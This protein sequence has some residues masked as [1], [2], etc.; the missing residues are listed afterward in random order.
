MSDAK[1]L[2]VDDEIDVLELCARILRS[3][4]YDVQTAQDGREAIDLA[5]GQHFDLLL[6]DIKMPGMSGLDIA[7]A[8]RKS[9]PGVICIAMT[10]FGTIDMVLDALKLGIDE[11]ILKPF[12]PQ[13]LKTTLLKATEKERL[14]KENFRLRSLIPLFELNETLLGTREVEKVFN[15]LL[16]ISTEETKASAAGIFIIE[17]EQVRSHPG[18]NGVFNPTLQKHL[19]GVAQR[20][21]K[22]PEQLHLSLNS[23]TGEDQKILKKLSAQALIATPIK[24]KEAAVIGTLILIKKGNN[25]APSDEEFLAV[26]SSQAGIALENARLFTEIEAAYK[27]LKQ[28]DHMK[29]EFINIAA[30]ELRTPLAILMGYASVLE[31]ETT[32]QNQEFAGR[33]IRNAMRLRALIEDM[34]NLNYLESGIAKLANDPLVLEDVV[35]DIMKD[36]SLLAEQKVLSVS[37][38]IPAKFPVIISDRQK[39]DLIAMNLVHNAIKFTPK[40]G[41]VGIKA[42]VNGD[43]VLVS[44][45]DSGIGIP[46]DQLDRIF[47]RFY[48]IE[49]SLTREYGGIGLGLAIVRAMVEVCGGEIFVESTEGKGTTFTFTLPLDNSNLETRKL[50]I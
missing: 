32:D 41:R 15:R 44:V 24:S 12:T 49:S 13:E 9:D 45:S 6:T 5:N 2:I 30:H 34:L 14:R 39:F 50:F 36:M 20:I 40:G 23:A 48:Q 7:R 21:F 46:G 29:R 4:G 16:E 10:G 1:V 22:N 25:F 31:E 37:I 3:K 27:E 42:R 11:F 35:K 8:L 47:D 17:N 38:D 18:N 33:I 19:F 43:Y 26:L 28:L